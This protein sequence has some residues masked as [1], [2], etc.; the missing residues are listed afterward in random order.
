MSTYE[1][2]LGPAAKRAVLGLRTESDANG[3][4]DALRQELADGPNADKQ[5]EFNVADKTYTATPL[6]FDGYT[7]VH[8][9]MARGELRR[10]G[11]EERRRVADR[12]FYVLDILR[13]ESGYLRRLP[14]PI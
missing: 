3:L 8:R 2:T 11:R 4:A 6:S 13:A 7:A 9:P 5:Y 14:S 12:G 1:V 10:L